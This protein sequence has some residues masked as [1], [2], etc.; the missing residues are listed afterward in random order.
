MIKKVIGADVSTA[1]AVDTGREIPRRSA[2]EHFIG[3]GK[4][5]MGRIYKEQLQGRVFSCRLCGTHLAS[6]LELI[7]K[8]WR[9]DAA[10][11]AP[12]PGCTRRPLTCAHAHALTTPVSLLRRASTAGRGKPTC[13]MRLST[14]QRAPG[15]NGS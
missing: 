4:A 11:R 8:V 1:I 3:V 14:C 2:V 15:R 12:G 9:L 6:N 7:S 5:A 13:S 10:L